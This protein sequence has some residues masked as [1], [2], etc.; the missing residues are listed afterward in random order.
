MV[1]KEDM[2]LLQE[3]RLEVRRI[4]LKHGGVI[5]E[6]DTTCTMPPMTEEMKMNLAHDLQMLLNKIEDQD[7]AT[8]ENE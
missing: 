2:P 1:G 6:N 4:F 8:Q 5:A 7:N 3:N